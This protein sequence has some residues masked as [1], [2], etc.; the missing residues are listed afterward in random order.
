MKTNTRTAA[1]SATATEPR[2]ASL[3]SAAAFFGTTVQVDLEKACIL[4]AAVI[5]IGPA[6]GHGF[7]ID[8]TTLDQVATLINAN[9]SGVPV[10]FKHPAMPTE[11]SPQPD[12][13][14][15]DV[16]YVRNARVEGESVR[17]DVYLMDYAEV[18]PGLGNVKDYLLRKAKS[19]PTGFGLS[20]VIAFGVEDQSDASGNVTGLVARVSGVDAVDFVSRPAANPNGLLST[21]LPNPVPPKA[22]LNT[23][24]SKMDPK[25]KSYLIANCGLSADATDE[26]A[27]EAF[28]GLSPE[29][30]AKANASM[31]AKPAPATPL[32]SKTDPVAIAAAAL[33]TQKA[34]L[35]AEGERVSMLRQLGQTL[36]V[37]ETVIL[38]AIADNDDVTKAKTRY[39]SHLATKCKPVEGL[40]VRVGPDQKT[41][42]LSAAIPDAIMLRAGQ[43]VEKPHELAVNLRHLTVLDIYRHYL[44]ANGAPADQVNFMSRP[45]LADLLGARACARAFPGVAQLAQGTT[46]FDNILLDA[47]NKTARAE[48]LLAP[49]TWEIWARRAT[50]PDFKNI[51]RVQLSDSPG[52]VARNEGGEIKYSTL[53]DSKESYVLAE[54]VNGLR[55]TR[56]AMV[57]DDLDM[58]SRIPRS[59]MQA[60]KQLEDDV[61][62][63]ILTAN[64]ALSDTV[65]LFH[66]THSNLISAT[67][68]LGAPSVTT[69]GAC[70]RLLRKQTGPKGN[71]LN[72]LAKYLLVP[73]ALETVA[74]QYTSSAFVPALSTSINP[75]AS[76]GRTPLI[77]VVE[78]RL[79]ATSSTAFYTV[80]D[81]SVIDTIECCFL[82]GEEAPQLKQ[83]SDW[84]TDDL[85]LAV[86]HTVAAKAIDHRGMVLNPG[87]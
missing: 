1:L 24:V 38:S 44:I 65:A 20:A 74:D 63:A 73:A 87:A 84:D 67:A 62:Y 7:N 11:D 25:V 51:N 71:K 14:G 61:V 86:R 28:D 76:N 72:L 46:S 75:F 57:N 2:I 42:A 35:I 16:G 60:A 58:F 31:S 6:E 47:A 41:A 79:D 18:L 49:S 53:S 4:N 39:L 83:E 29:D 30:Q 21:K 43:K 17:G 80:A 68:E 55:L 3:R 78:S 22:G 12:A 82:Q 81:N 66:A 40:N 15:T 70:R 52:L 26:Q 45:R 64:A 34:Q 36:N 69:L 77:P 59:Q 5:T 13:L 33:Q 19:D 56:R 37:D 32:A 10:R 50:A 27:Q 9:P 23:G 54:Y 85:K 48:Y 8:A